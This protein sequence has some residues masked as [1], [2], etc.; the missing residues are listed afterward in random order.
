V[1]AKNATVHDGTQRQIIKDLATPAPYV[2]AAI[3]TLAFVVE[4][5]NLGDLPRLVVSTDESY[6]IRVSHFERQKK[7]ESFNAV[8]PS[9]HEVSWFDGGARGVRIEE[10]DLVQIPTD[11]DVI[12]LWACAPNLEELH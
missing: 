5:V 4:P 12:R 7:E 8:E 2:A 9:I 3:L 6:A 1:D 10:I 11:E